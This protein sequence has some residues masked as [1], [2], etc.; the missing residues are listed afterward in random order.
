MRKIFSGI[1]LAACALLVMGAAHAGTAGPT[2]VLGKVGVAP[3]ATI[4]FTAPT[5]NTDGTPID[6]PISFELF[7]GVS[8]SSLAPVAHGLTGSPIAVKTG[9]ADGETLYW[10][11]VT[12]DAQGDMSAPSNVVCKTFPHPVPNTVTITVS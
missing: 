8:P 12:V 2:C 9:L 5:T 3:T 1:L 4:T 11:V 10:D 6:T 7:Q